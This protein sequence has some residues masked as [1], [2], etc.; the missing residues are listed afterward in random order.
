MLAE[1]DLWIP[2]SWVSEE[3][4][5][6]V[7]RGCQQEEM[8]SWVGGWRWQRFGG[9]LTSPAPGESAGREHVYPAPVP[10]TLEGSHNGVDPALGHI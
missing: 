5:C 4:A 8:P 3:V 6:I 7:Q 9:D 1:N 2:R 10:G